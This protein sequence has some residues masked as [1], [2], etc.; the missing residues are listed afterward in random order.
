MAE[1]NLDSG[2]INFWSGSD[3]QKIFMNGDQDITSLS[4][5][6]PTTLVINHNLGY[7]PM[8]RVWATDSNGDIGETYNWGM[9]AQA[10]WFAAAVWWRVTT[11]QLIIYIDDF[12]ATQTRHV[13]YRIYLDAA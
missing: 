7:F 1:L 5:L 12:T 13:W 6:S 9:G 3:F 11:T 10:P 2:L 4:A 8:C